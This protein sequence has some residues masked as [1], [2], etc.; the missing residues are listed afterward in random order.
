MDRGHVVAVLVAVVAVDLARGFVLGDRVA[1]VQ[2]DTGKI[3]TTMDFVREDVS[4]IK[5]DIKAVRSDLERV[6][7]AVGATQPEEK[8]AELA[9]RQ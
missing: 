7:A 6:A 8:K 1:D 5:A 2:V 4:E 3:A 9:P